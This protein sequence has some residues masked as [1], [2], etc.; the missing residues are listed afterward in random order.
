M[1]MKCYK[2]RTFQKKLCQAAGN[3]RPGT[4]LYTP[5]EYGRSADNGAFRDRCNEKEER[6]LIT[7]DITKDSTFEEEV[8]LITTEMKKISWMPVSCYLWLY[9]FRFQPSER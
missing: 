3:V 9:E 7:V 1:R 8:E 2:T 4:P 5:P 6:C